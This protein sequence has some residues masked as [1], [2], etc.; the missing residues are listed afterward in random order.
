[1]LPATEASGGLSISYWNGRGVVSLHPPGQKQCVLP[2][3]L[4]RDRVEQGECRAGLVAG[5]GLQATAWC[6]LLGA[7]SVSAPNWVCMAG[8]GGVHSMEQLAGR[9]PVGR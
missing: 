8:G 3:Q 4:L 7:A 2:N 9:G 5:A 1:M 6:W